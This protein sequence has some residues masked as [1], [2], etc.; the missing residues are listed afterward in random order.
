MTIYVEGK[1]VVGIYLNGT[2]VNAAYANGVQIFSSKEG[3][4]ENGTVTWT[5]TAANSNSISGTM[6]LTRYDYYQSGQVTQVRYDVTGTNL[7][8]TDVGILN[9]PLAS[10]NTP[11]LAFTDS[12]IP[13]Y[14]YIISL[15]SGTGINLSAQEFS[16]LKQIT[17][18][19]G[20]QTL[21][22]LS[23]TSNYLGP[24]YGMRLTIASGI[25][26][27][28][29]S[30]WSIANNRTSRLGTQ[31]EITTSLSALD[32]P[33]TQEGVFPVYAVGESATEGTVSA[34]TCSQAAHATY[35]G[36]LIRHIGYIMVSNGAISATDSFGEINTQQI[37]RSLSGANVT[38]TAGFAQDTD[39]YSVYVPG[40]TYNYQS[41]ID[42]A[43]SKTTTNLVELGTDYNYV[44]SIYPVYAFLGSTDNT[45]VI[46]AGPATVVVD[47]EVNTSEWISFNMTSPMAT[48]GQTTYLGYKTAK[49]SSI[50]KVSGYQ[51]TRASTD[52][53]VP[54]KVR[55]TYDIP[56]GTNLTYLISSA[57]GN[58]QHAQSRLARITAYRQESST[59]PGTQQSMTLYAVVTRSTTGPGTTVAQ[60]G[61]TGDSTP[62]KSY[63]YIGTITV[64]AD[65]SVGTLT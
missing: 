32:V 52:A 9:L 13:D 28:V 1:K 61:S 15:T 35:D 7:S 62:F 19:D 33:S 10:T 21:T 65:A 29:G 51:F 14:K 40:F 49:D 27:G 59:T 11:M 48:N 50:Q 56:S 44:S 41:L 46:Q 4:E 34:I 38:V 6:T 55:W 31:T 45:E 30:G 63:V 23:L 22:N 2:T 26:L 3:W 37:V 16:R 60:Q 47:A 17:F 18:S 43:Q 36:K 5:V 39:G 57:G 12:S 53:S 54:Y 42:A 8:T 24:I 25:T 58:L 64:Q 20:W